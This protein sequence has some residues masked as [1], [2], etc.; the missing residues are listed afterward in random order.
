MRRRLV[1]VF[2]W[3]AA[4]GVELNDMMMSVGGQ[5]VTPV[6]FSAFNFTSFFYK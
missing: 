4:R 3:A 1:Y 6:F 5:L 2:C